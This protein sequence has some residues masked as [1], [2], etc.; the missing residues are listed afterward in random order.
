MAGTSPLVFNGFLETDTY[1]QSK[2]DLQQLLGM[3]DRAV[4]DRLAAL[5][6]SLQREPA[7]N[8]ERVGSRNLWVAVTP[9]GSPP[10]R[11]YMRPHATII[12]EWDLLWIEERP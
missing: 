9:G 2:L 5:I 8:C 11:I 12:G 6:W 3:S 4:D 7:T 1:E 10:I